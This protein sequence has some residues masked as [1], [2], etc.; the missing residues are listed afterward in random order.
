[1]G[2]NLK[3]PGSACGICGLVR[4]LAWG[5]Q[6]TNQG[7]S[8]PAGSGSW[9]CVIVPLE[10]FLQPRK[11]SQNS[12]THEI[13]RA[14]MELAWAHTTATCSV[15][16]VQ[17][18]AESKAEALAAAHP[19]LLQRT[20]PSVSVFSLSTAGWFLSTV[21]VLG[22]LSVPGFCGHLDCSERCTAG[23]SRC[24][25]YACHSLSNSIANLPMATS[26]RCPHRSVLLELSLPKK[27]TRYQRRRTVRNDDGVH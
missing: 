27:S 4:V 3:A 15:L 25:A 5:N 22:L 20:M 6:R 13:R 16:I 18:P 17:A 2:K 12:Y 9:R 19:P 11:W 10:P 23:D 26:S 7:L 1:M 14:H 21:R 8:G 24:A